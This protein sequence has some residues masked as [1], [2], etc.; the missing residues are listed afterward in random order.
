IRTAFMSVAATAMLPM[1]DILGLPSI[2]RMNLP[3]TAQGNWGWRMQSHQ[4]TSDLA[5]E[6]GELL[7][8][9]GRHG[10]QL[11]S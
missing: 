9:Y 7:R 3:G 1:Q 4:L 5:A 10:N 8:R 11:K 2:A 6:F